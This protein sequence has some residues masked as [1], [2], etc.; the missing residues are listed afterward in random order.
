MTRHTTQRGSLLLEL[1][2]ACAVLAIML[3]LLIPSLWQLK[4]RHNLALT[5]LDQAAFRSALTAQFKA[6]WARLLPA[7]CSIDTG[8][9]LTIGSSSNV[10]ARLSQRSMSNQSDWLEAIDYGACRISLDAI[11]DPIETTNSCDLSVGDRVRVTT[12]EA[13]MQV[14]VTQSTNQKLKFNLPTSTGSSVLNQTGIL[15]SQAGFYWY[16]GEGKI[17]QQALWRTPKISGNSLELWSGLKALAI[18]PL[19]D[20][21]ADGLVD[22]IETR[23][24]EYSLS[25]VRAVWVEYLY[26]LDNCK[27]SSQLTQP[28]YYQ[29]MRGDQ[30]EYFSPCQ[31]VGNKIIVL[32]GVG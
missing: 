22:S 15:E 8:L 4:T 18:L 13:S 19:M 26:E 31:G 27:A 28:Q 17:G 16:A 7:G 2:V 10:P 5:Y 20:E 1:M 32:N 24:G 3:P 21:D 29:T 30:W 14:Q 12:C 9:R 25:K 11:Q 23:Y 6:H